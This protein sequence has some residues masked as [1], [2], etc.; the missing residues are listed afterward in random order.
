[1]KKKQLYNIWLVVFRHRSEKSE[2][3]SWDDYPIY[4]GKIKFM[5]QTTNQNIDFQISGFLIGNLYAT[6]NRQTVDFPSH[7][8]L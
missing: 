1:M 5:F 2:L 7:K 8:M 3:V 6:E 4:Y